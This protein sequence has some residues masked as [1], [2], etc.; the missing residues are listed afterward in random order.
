MLKVVKNP[1]PPGACFQLVQAAML[2]A[3][4]QCLNCK[5]YGPYIHMVLFFCIF[6]LSVTLMFKSELKYNTEMLSNQPQRGR[7][8]WPYGEKP[9][10]GKFYIP[11]LV[12]EF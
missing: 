5:K 7:P 6:V 10:L 11:G 8:C 4:F 9:M 12:T 2:S 3:L 1:D